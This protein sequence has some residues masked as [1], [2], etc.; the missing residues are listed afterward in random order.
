VG[1]QVVSLQAADQITAFFQDALNYHSNLKISSLI[2]SGLMLAAIP[3][4]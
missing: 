3:S 4:M 2:F 1:N